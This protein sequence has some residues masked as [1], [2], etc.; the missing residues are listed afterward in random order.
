MRKL[1]LRTLLCLSL[2]CTALSPVLASAAPAT[3]D[4]SVAMARE[5]FKEGVAF[6]DKKDYEK[7]RLAFLQAYALKKH[8]AVLLNLAQ[9]ELRSG[10]EADAARH[11]AAYLRD[12]TD[13]SPA[14]S[15][16]A[17]AGLN[18]AKIAVAE[19]EVTVDESGAEV[20]VDGTLSGVSPLPGP[21]YMAVGSHSVEA[22]K[23]GQ[24]TATQVSASA[25]KQLKASLTLTPK[26]A[27]VAAPPSVPAPEAATSPE[28]EAPPEEGGGRKPFFKW[29]VGSPVGLVGL[30]LTGVGVGGGIGFAIASHKSYSNSDSVANQ[31]KQAAIADSGSPMPD[32]TN[33]CNDPT[34]W[35]ND[36]GYSN[37][38][39]PSLAQRAS[40]YSNAC[41]KY[42]DNVHKGDT[43]K[44]LSTVGFVVGGVAAVGT[45]VYYFVDPHAKEASGEA[46]THHRRV[47]LVPSVSPGQTSL[48]LLGSF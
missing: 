19:V 23:N 29:L 35:L 39:T 7:A 6:F 14:E 32:T 25:G 31:I 5:R 26:A 30:G 16:A 36:N 24:S 8:P 18:A 41:A 40:E 21:L 20:Y 27:P 11:F 13:A 4:A 46:S 42:P 43:F 44:T 12:A 37:N 38:K 48:T 22:R 34:R 9:S 2:A 28:P 45:I 33:L 3:D 1:R 47:A 15:Q 17:Q 10:H